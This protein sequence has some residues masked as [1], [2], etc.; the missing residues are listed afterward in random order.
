MD[1]TLDPNVTVTDY[2]P[3]VFTTPCDTESAVRGGRLP[4]AVFYCIL[5]VLGLLGNG[6]V[7]LVLVACKKLGSIT[8]IYLLNLAVS[9]LLFVFS[10][11]FQTHYLL[12]QW[13]FGTAVCKAVSGFYYVGF[14]SSMFFVTLMSVDRYLAVVHAVY[15][16]RVR[17]AR[18]GGALSLAVWLTAVAATL[19]LLVFYQVAPDDGTLQCFPF[20]DNQSLRWKLSVH[21]EVNVLGLLLPFAV[22]LFCYIRVLQQLRGCQNHN[23][24]RAV[25]LVLAVVIASLLFW[26]PF[27]AVLF[28]GSLHD[29]RVLDGCAVS[30]GLALA[31]H[32]TE[33]I[34]FTHCCVNPVIYAF[35]GEKFK[36]N[37]A[38]V[39]QK[40]C[41][42]I[43]LHV[44]GRAPL[45]AWERQLS[46]NQRSSHSSTLD[47]IL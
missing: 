40:S 37:L 5:F 23:R 45:G 12:D 1:H 13:V 42:H 20:Y 10:V 9:D 19:P 22:L 24:T 6:L 18:V 31:T 16:L 3:D 8:D 4:L 34:S 21:F 7:I 27:N 15:A 46:S 41:S 35:I 33:V 29:L 44:G 43:F 17:T 28:L 36:K 39:F 32:V 47:Y 38:A 30:Q 26:V 11:P 25:K 14:F 2:Y